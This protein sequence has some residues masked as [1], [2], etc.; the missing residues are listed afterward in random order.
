MIENGSETGLWRP[1]P[2]FQILALQFAFPRQNSGFIST[3][4]QDLARSPNITKARRKTSE[5]T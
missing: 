5:R 2:L 3:P 1:D 4:L